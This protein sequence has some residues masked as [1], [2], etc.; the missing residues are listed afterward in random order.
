MPKAETSVGSLAATRRR[1]AVPIAVLFY[2]AVAVLFSWPLTANLRTHIAGF[3]GD[4]FLHLWGVW[5]LIH[6]ATTPGVAMFETTMLFA[7]E[8]TSLALNDPVPLVALVTAAVEPWLG[9]VGGF[10]LA[11]LL[12]MTFGALG[13]FLLARDVSG[14][15]W[16]GL[17]GGV[18]FG[19]SPF[20]M[21]QSL[22]HV[23]YATAVAVPFAVW[24]WW[25]SRDDGSWRWSM[26]LALS[27]IAVGLT[28]AYYA[29]YL[30]VF[31]LFGMA[32]DAVSVGGGW[33]VRPL[34]AGLGLLRR[35][36]DGL[37]MGMLAAMVVIVASGGGRFE[38]AGR[39]LSVG[40][41]GNPALAFWVLLALRVWLVRRVD[42]RVSVDRERLIAGMKRVALPVVAM[43]TVMVPTVLATLRLIFAGDYPEVGGSFRNTAPGADLLAFVMPQPLHPLWGGAVEGWYQGL[44]LGMV[45]NVVFLGWTSFALVLAGRP[46]KVPS[47]RFWTAAF[48]FFGLLALGPFLR[49]GGLETWFPFLPFQ[50]LRAIPV[51]AQA[52]IPGRFA[53]LVM[54]ALSV[55]V[56]LAV[57]KLGRRRRIGVG[58]LAGIVVVLVLFEALPAPFP[59]SDARVPRTHLALAEEAGTGAVLELPFSAG[60]GGGGWG[61]LGPR[62]QSF[63]RAHGKPLV[64]GYI[65]RLPPSAWERVRSEPVLEVVTRLQSGELRSR[66][67]RERV[68][69]E[70]FSDLLQRHEVD[71]ISV[72]VRRTRTRVLK[73]VE[74][75]IGEGPTFLEDGFAVWRVETAVDP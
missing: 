74:R 2:G 66:E 36:L 26:G 33:K 8:G 20:L 7:P 34:A 45:D 72:D 52:R 55:L 5:W 38:I 17:L 65:A 41:I 50:V 18:V 54:L 44:P 23:G 11:C 30:L 9:L 49:V 39:E 25:R 64:G 69:A 27:L 10:N 6:A 19:F 43:L 21:A 61:E 29:V 48:G 57:A 62:A 3:E 28:H 70:D 13:A 4:N 63:Q 32:W 56:A 59:I 53:V 68:S 24:C 47:G 51:F 14:N 75:M 22:G 16:A 37:L 12:S 67:A 58:G 31:L 73:W 71:W 60:D 46:W 42:A 40:S 1:W 35:V 15:A